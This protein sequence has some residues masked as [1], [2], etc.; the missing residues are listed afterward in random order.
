[1]RTVMFSSLSRQWELASKVRRDTHAFP[2]SQAAVT[3]WNTPRKQA[4]SLRCAAGPA[5]DGLPQTVCCRSLTGD[6]PCTLA[7][8]SQSASSN[9]AARDSKERMASG[10]ELLPIMRSNKTN[11]QRR[12][13]R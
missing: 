13:Q 12:D 2:G 9:R 7:P 8:D 5:K 11:F 4:K 10:V 1:M 6:V 3:Q